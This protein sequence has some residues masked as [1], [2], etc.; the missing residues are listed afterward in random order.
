M[1]RLVRAATVVVLG[2]SA[3]RLERVDPRG[4]LRDLPLI[5]RAAT[6]SGSTFAVL[7]T[8]DGGWAAADRGLST[9]LVSHG[10]PVVAL[11]A[12]RYLAERRTPDESARD[13]A[14]I[15]RHYERTWRRNQVL[16]LGYSRGADIVPFMVA[17]LPNDLRRG[18]TLVALLGPSAWVGFRFHP[19]DL[20]ANV[21]RAG[22]LP[23]IPEIERLVG[24]PV[25]CIY[26]RNDR[27]AICPE[28]DSTLARLVVRDGG[29]GVRE[30]EGPALVDTILH[31]NNHPEENN[32]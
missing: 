15:I 5:E 4:D 10:V 31:Y 14:R 32:P 3:C 8:G 16:A 30:A 24:T 6:G 25:L 26:G 13:L 17:R 1:T 2:L 27:H 20:I 18:V 12:P 19:L 7:M 9:S 11:D 21:H 23:V 28:L 22:D 29:H